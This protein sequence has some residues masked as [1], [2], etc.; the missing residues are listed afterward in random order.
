MTLHHSHILTNVLQPYYILL[1]GLYLWPCFH[2]LSRQIEDN[3]PLPKTDIQTE[4]QIKQTYLELN[5]KC[6]ESEMK[7]IIWDCCLLLGL[8]HI[9][10]AAQMQTRG[11]FHTLMLSRPVGGLI[12]IEIWFLHNSVRVLFCFFHSILD[13][14]QSTANKKQRQK[15]KT[16]NN[17][18]LEFSETCKQPKWRMTCGC[19]IMLDVGGWYRLLHWLCKCIW[20][21]VEIT[22]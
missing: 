18:P 15:D 10:R 19:Y 20:E 9:I 13:S 2:S 12:L 5:V 11:H 22:E 6:S 14:Q 21:G 3:L 1:N 4:L 8:L 7:P 16:V 17:I